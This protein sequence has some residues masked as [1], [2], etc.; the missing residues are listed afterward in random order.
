[1]LSVVAT[2]RRALNHSGAMV[3]RERQAPLNSSISDRKASNSCVT[4]M[5]SVLSIPGTMPDYTGG[6]TSLM[7]AR[8]TQETRW[9]RR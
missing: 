3:A 2:R 9:E 5:V 4:W 1:M 6:T 8:D 7:K